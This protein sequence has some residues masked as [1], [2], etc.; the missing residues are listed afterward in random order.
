VA[1]VTNKP[2]E[3]KATSRPLRY[4][5]LGL[6]VLFLGVF[7]MSGLHRSFTLETLVEHHMA[8]RGFV[9]AHPLATA[10]LYLLIYTAM[11]ALSIPVSVFLAMTGGFLFGWLLGGALAAIGST[12][13][14]ASI[15]LVARTSIGEPIL[16]RAGPRIQ[17]FAASFRA[18]SFSYLLFL[19]LLPIMP[20]WITN[21]AAAVFGMRF[22]TFL[23]A[24]QIGVVP[25][26]YAFAAAGSGLEA[27]IVAHEQQLAE[28]LAAG[29]T[30]CDMDFR[31]ESLLTPQ[32]MVALGLLGLLALG[33][34]IVRKWQAL[35]EETKG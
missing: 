27:A 1:G 29:K 8:M 31:P 23:L 5:P 18:D 25:I 21:L 34:I 13:G 33:P 2:E 15:F 10:A 22:K 17:R 26:C 24:T 4:L 12:F 30:D 28:C 32:L 35:R 9:T 3:G 7:F 16:R 20:F 6:V 19:R 14:A 11:V